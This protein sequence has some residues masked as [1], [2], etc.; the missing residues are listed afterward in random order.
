MTVHRA[1]RQGAHGLRIACHG[2]VLRDGGSVAGAGYLLVRSLL[3]LGHEVDL[4][5][6]AGHVDD[7]GFQHAA[8]RYV[9][10][11]PK[12]GSYLPAAATK[13]TPLGLAIHRMRHAPQQRQTS[14][15][16]R[17]LVQERHSVRPYHVSLHLGL[18]PQFRIAGLPTVSWPQGAPGLERD[19]LV[20]NRQLVS[21]VSG[22]VIYRG[23]VSYYTIKD[24]GAWRWMKAPL[25]YVVTAS[26]LSR[27][28]VIDFG[29]APERVKVIPYPIGTDDDTEAWPSPHTPSRAR[30]LTIGRW[31]AR[32]RVDLAIDSVLELRRRGC[33]ASLD[34]VGRPGA[35]PGW[36]E[37]LAAR[38][39]SHIRVQGAVS[40]LEAQRLIGTATA[41]LQ[42]SENEEFGSV[43]AEALSHGVPAVVGP[44]NG[45]GQYLSPDTGVIFSRYSATAVADALSTAVALAREPST[46]ATCRAAAAHQF[47]PM[48]VA[49]QL[50]DVLHAA[51]GDAGGL[52]RCLERSS[53]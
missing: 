45:T 2:W 15:R 50:V 3:D 23:V 11:D 13:Q 19:A 6:A 12:S 28:Q 21:E 1:G 44:S 22:S 25:T 49:S 34:I 9:R 20:R 41:V 31:D 7:P 33:D 51:V 4:F 35:L 29:V 30:F 47:R 24:A 5:G 52:P 40:F 8:F 10:A 53:G 17:G 39:D 42:T 37:Y 16:L 43:V 48:S 38:A 14:A 36:P 32:K 46:A 26:S 18:A 27:S